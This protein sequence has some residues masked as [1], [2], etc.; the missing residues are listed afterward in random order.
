[1]A[2]FFSLLRRVD[3]TLLVRHLA[4]CAGAV[5]AYLYQDSLLAENGVVW[6]ISLAVLLN[7]ILALLWDRH[8][9]APWV[10]LLSP[11][12]G[13]ASWSILA[14]FTGGVRS[15]FITGFW[16]EILLSALAFSTRGTL[17]ITLV[18]ILALWVQQAFLGFPGSLRIL[19]L[20]CGFL[21]V[22]GLAALLLTLRWESAHREF[23]LRKG[24]LDDRLV[25]L[26]RELESVRRVGMAG[27][28]VARLAHSVKNAIHAMRGFTALIQKMLDGREG[29]C[30]ALDGLQSCIE[31]LEEVV[32]LTFGHPESPGGQERVSD[33]AGIRQAIEKVIGEVTVS[34]PEIRW[35]LHVDEPLP[36]STL[37]P[38]IT[39]EVLLS[40]ARNAAEAMRGRGDVAIE[41]RVA[42]GSLEIAVRDQGTGIT[43]S[44][45]RRMFSPGYTTKS[46]G[47]GF[48][49]FLARRVMESYG[50]FLKA[51]P[52][53]EGGAVFS[54]G[55]PLERS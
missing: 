30:Q 40:L 55:I 51:I 6:L 21:S 43:D 3:T 44:D 25:R 26:E 27:E 20:Q 33:G 54:I 11:A 4:I 38:S 12:L 1:M 52:G 42:N 23:S 41:C 31:R 5:V 48:G 16:L 32:S 14:A 34:Y 7:F 9:L 18:S 2:R 22:M 53:G 29:S 24:E 10:R 17:I 47:A 37:P 36:L 28:N 46:D 39:H 19:L 8:K 13:I 45:L 35:S 49:L 50:G 15:P